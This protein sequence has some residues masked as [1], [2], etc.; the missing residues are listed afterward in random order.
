[1]TDVGMEGTIIYLDM[2]RNQ[3]FQRERVT[4]EIFIRHIVS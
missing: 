4:V 3:I 2:W 1:M